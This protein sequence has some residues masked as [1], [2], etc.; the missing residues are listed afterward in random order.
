M[1]KRSRPRWGAACILLLVVR[2]ERADRDRQRARSAAEAAARRAAALRSASRFG[3]REHKPGELSESV[4]PAG[5]EGV[6]LP[7]GGGPPAL[8]RD[9]SAPAAA[10]AQGL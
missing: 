8:T 4:V 5:P 7:A 9:P 6:P 1:E 10:P 3:G 2:L